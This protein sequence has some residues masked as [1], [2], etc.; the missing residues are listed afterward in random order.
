MLA[1]GSCRVQGCGCSAVNG[2]VS[3]D[4][5][6]SPRRTRGN[7]RCSMIGIK[8]I[9]VFVYRR[10]VWARSIPGKL[11][12]NV[13]SEKEYVYVCVCFRYG[14]C[15]SKVAPTL[16][17]ASRWRNPISHQAKWLL[18]NTITPTL[19]KSNSGV[20]TQTSVQENCRRWL[21][22]RSL[23]MHLPDFDATHYRGRGLDIMVVLLRV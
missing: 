18:S 5:F 6:I 22:K 23:L 4:D 8:Q 17:E 16:S 3:R 13:P 9:H 7:S 2:S 21:S 11:Q 19:T 14:T 10:H 15:Y 20:N 12:A 1:Q